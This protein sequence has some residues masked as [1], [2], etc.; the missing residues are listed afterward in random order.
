M[1]EEKRVDEKQDKDPSESREVPD[2][3]DSDESIHTDSS[4]HSESTYTHTDSTHTRTPDTRTDTYTSVD[5]TSNNT[6]KQATNQYTEDFS[7]SQSASSSRTTSPPPELPSQPPPPLPH[8]TASH[9]SHSTS[10]MIHTDE[11]VSI[12]EDQSDAS[13][14][15]F[16]LADSQSEVSKPTVDQSKPDIVADIT[17]CEDLLSAFSVGQRVLVGGVQ[18]GTLRFKGRTSFA[19]G[20]WGGIELDTNEGYNNGSK[21]GVNYFN[22]AEKRGIFA[23]P[24]KISALSSRRDSDVHESIDESLSSDIS[25]HTLTEVDDAHPQTDDITDLLDTVMKPADS[26]ENQQEQPETEQ[27]D[28]K[29]DAITESLTKSVLQEAVDVMSNISDT[30]DKHAD[31]I[32]AKPARDDVEEQTVPESKEDEVAPKG[33]EVKAVESTTSALLTDAI[34]HMMKI[35]KKKQE[36]LDNQSNQQVT[37][38][39]TNERNLEKDIERHADD[40]RSI[41]PGSITSGKSSS[42]VTDEKNNELSKNQ[43]ALVSLTIK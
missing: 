34:S 6:S 2:G 33:T 1:Q 27:M 24:E 40:S 32:P 20:F 28:Q 38:L 43:A 10:S 35:R 21:D 19:P 30:K 5:S 14:Q 4:V 42:Y 15:A 22:C 12:I 39:V 25:E 17:E 9:S 13:D 26:Q 11:E 41:M 8:T 37:D 16:R 31:D 29:V 7:T 36:S 23:P 18:P 3:P